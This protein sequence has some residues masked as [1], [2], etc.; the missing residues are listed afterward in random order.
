MLKYHK[1]EVILK[2]HPIKPHPFIGSTIR[3]AFGVSLKKVV[4]INPSFECNGCFAKDNCL[5]YEFYEQKNRAH[6]YRFDIKL[7][8]D[9]YDFGLYLFEDA[10]EKL[11]YVVSTIDMMFTKQGITKDR[12]KI[13]IDR[14]VCNGKEIYH[15]GKYDLSGIEPMEFKPKEIISPVTLQLQTPLRMKSQ[16]KLLTNKPKLE[17]L[18]YSIHN[19]LNEI[20]EL[21]KTKLTYKPS[22]KEVESSVRFTDQTRRSNRQKTKLQIGGITGYL[23]YEDID[24][25]SLIYLNL[26]EILGVGKQTVF[27]M[28]KIEV[29]NF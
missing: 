14:I 27:G 22:Y 18:L 17:T 15:N 5:F 7:N 4:C 6:R 2:P 13:D 1:I 19:R 28:G 12:I 25:N 23:K 11:P 10:T 24:E 16:G 29:K 8:P 20:K 21:P 9:T 3:G 26:G